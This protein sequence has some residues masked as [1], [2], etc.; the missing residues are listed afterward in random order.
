MS[1]LVKSTLD[2]A[3]NHAI[4]PAITLKASR[5]FSRRRLNTEPT[6]VYLTITVTCLLKRVRIKL[7]TIQDWER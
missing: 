5:R 4:G 2:M 3:A 7:E 1:E 6:S